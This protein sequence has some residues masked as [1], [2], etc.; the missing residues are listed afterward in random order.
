MDLMWGPSVLPNE[1]D[2]YENLSLED[3][4]TFLGQVELVSG[5]SRSE[6]AGVTFE[7]DGIFKTLLQEELAAFDHFIDSALRL[8]FGFTAFVSGERSGVIGS[9]IK[10]VVVIPG[11]LYHTHPGFLAV[12]L[13]FA[14]L[15]V[16]IAGGAICRH[17]ALEAGPRSPPTLVHAVSFAAKRYHWLALCPVIP[18]AII[19]VIGL[20]LAVVGLLFNVPVLDVL[21]GLGF[22]LMLF[23]GLVIS[24]LLIGGTA[25]SGLMFPAV[26]AEDADA[27]DA[28][29]RSYGYVFARPWH[30]LF[31]NA[32]AAV[33]GALTYLLVGLV[34]FLAL[35]ATKT[36]ADMF[37]FRDAVPGVSRLDAMLVDPRLGNLVPEVSPASDSLSATG[38]AAAWLIAVWVRLLILLLPAF[39]VSYFFSAQTWV[40]LLLRRSADGVDYDQVHR[41]AKPDAAATL[42]PDKI[43]DADAGAGA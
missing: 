26:A 4:H 25:A 23:G 30:W 37:V 27:F 33:Y 5:R 13:L 22:G 16:C 6:F 32:V 2:A 11:W 21:A 17:A 40:Y 1:V 38:Q 12:Y 20:I 35:W 41:D 24:L 7:T 36:F 8:H 18:L 43:E 9:L 34:V 19:F 14:F 31:Y 15:L 29:S 28:V 3:Y 39:A 42:S 10:M